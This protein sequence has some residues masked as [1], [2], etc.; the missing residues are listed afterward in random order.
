MSVSAQTDQRKV[1]CSCIG[2]RYSK[3]RQSTRNGKTTEGAKACPR[4][5]NIDSSSS[6]AIRIA[7]TQVSSNVPARTIHSSHAGISVRGRQFC[8]HV[9]VDSLLRVDLRA[10]VDAVLGIVAEELVLVLVPLDRVERAVPG[11]KFPGALEVHRMPEL[12]F[13]RHVYVD[14]DAC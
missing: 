10:V 11:G 5:S 12:R 1:H 4:E 9:D 6:I 7:E 2:Y 13:L 8:T 3:K 14:F